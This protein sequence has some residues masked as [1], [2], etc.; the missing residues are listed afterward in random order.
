MKTVL[1]TLLMATLADDLIAN[2][3]L[4]ELVVVGVH[5]VGIVEMI[6]HGVIFQTRLFIYFIGSSIPLIKS[7]QHLQL[8]TLFRVVLWRK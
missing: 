6:V 7:I 2:L 1:P 8:T 4:D 5:S 3:K